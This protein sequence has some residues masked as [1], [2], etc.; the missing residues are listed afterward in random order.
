MSATTEK[1]IK[2]VLLLCFAGCYLLA[3]EAKQ[4]R[5]PDAVVALTPAALRK[6]A[7]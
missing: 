6:L 1:L 3:M 5:G 7:R 4:G 2:I